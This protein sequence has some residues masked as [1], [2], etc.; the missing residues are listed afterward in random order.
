MIPEQKHCTVINIIN[1][2]VGGAT[3]QAACCPPTCRRQHV[4]PLKAVFTS[5]WVVSCLGD[6][7]LTLVKHGGGRNDTRGRDFP[8]P[9]VQVLNLLFL[10]GLKVL[11]LHLVSVNRQETRSYSGLRQTRLRSA[12]ILN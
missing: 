6:A 7:P 3:L 11:H 8:H 9:L 1:R 4:Q 2:S 5:R 10:I 12:E